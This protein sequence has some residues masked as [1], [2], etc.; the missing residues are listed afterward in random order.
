LNALFMDRS[1][2]RFEFFFKGSSFP[3][4]CVMLL[5]EA[6]SYQWKLCVTVTSE[7]PIRIGTWLVWPEN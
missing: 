2:C 4:N 1:F 3:F 5:R 6:Q 7:M